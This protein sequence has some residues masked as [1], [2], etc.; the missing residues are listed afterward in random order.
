MPNEIYNIELEVVTPLCVGVG[1]DKDWIQGADYIIKG[2]TVYVIDIRKAAQHNLN[3]LLKMF[4]YSDKSICNLSDEQLQKISRYVYQAPVGRIREIKSALRSSLHGIPIVAGSSLKGAIRSALFN[5]FRSENETTNLAVL[6]D[7]NK[8]TDF[9]RFLQVGDIEIPSINSGGK[10]ISSTTL[11]NA[12]LFNLYKKGDNWFGGWKEKNTDKA[13]GFLDFHTVDIF[14]EDSFNTVYECIKPGMKG[15]GYIAMKNNAFNLLSSVQISHQE[16][17]KKLLK[18][19]N[20]TLFEIINKQT[21]AYLEKEL[22]FFNNYKTENNRAEEIVLCIRTLLSIINRS[23]GSYCLVKMSA[24]VGFHAI[25]GDW[26]NVS[27]NYV[28]TGEWKK[29]EDE[30]LVGRRKYKSRKIAIYKRELQLMGFVKLTDLTIAK[31]K[32]E[33]LNNYQDLITEAQELLKTNRLEDA[34]KKAHEAAKIL[35]N[36][37]DHLEI[38]KSVTEKKYGTT[39]K[40][41]QAL[42]E[43]GKLKEAKQKANEAAGINPNGNAHSEIIRIADKYNKSYGLLIKD[44]KYAD[45]LISTTEKWLKYNGRSFGNAEYIELQRVVSTLQ[46]KE[47]NKLEKSKKLIDAISPLWAEKLFPKQETKKQP[48]EQGLKEN[49]ERIVSEVKNVETIQLKETEPIQTQPALEIKEKETKEEATPSRKDETQQQ[50]QL[51]EESIIS[52]ISKWFKN[53]F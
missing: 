16:K 11:V 36:G 43:E 15:K 24:G 7:M 13:N 49:E 34:I 32:Q 47:L 46:K 5:H 52:R 18:G 20:K 50:E 26:Q 14:R 12:R 10:T 38:L 53:L 51:P 39:I 4:T 29:G 21:K 1:T 37:E 44:A 17:K 25:T 6:G 33:T 45:S 30:K 48:K 28:E 23:D 22:A 31:Q 40:V 3:E 41:A 8:G 2:S 19:G 9:M 35:P 42:L 27:K